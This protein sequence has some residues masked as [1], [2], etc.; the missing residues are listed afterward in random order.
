MLHTEVDEGADDDLTLV[1]V[2]G[3]ALNLDCW[4]F[5]RLHFRGRLRQGLLRPALPWQV[6][7]LGGGA[8]QDSPAGRGP[9]PGPRRRSSAPDQWF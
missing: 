4:H 7:P 6:N 8:L 5:Q 2:H 3:Y 9:V 1:F